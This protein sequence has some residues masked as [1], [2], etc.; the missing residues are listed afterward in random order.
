MML[1]GTISIVTLGLYTELIKGRRSLNKAMDTRTGIFNNGVLV[2][3]AE[4]GQ[5]LDFVFYFRH[6][7]QNSS[8][9]KLKMENKRA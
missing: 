7:V 6:I 3:E 2:S 4:Y 8:Y 5:W 1:L 9:F